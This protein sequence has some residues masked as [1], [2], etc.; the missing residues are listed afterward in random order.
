MDP[1]TIAAILSS[2]KVKAAIQG[3]EKD[4]VGAGKQALIGRLQPTA[5]ERAAK[6]AIKLFSEQWNEELEATSFLGAAI[7]PLRTQ[8]N[9][10]V[11]T[12]AAEIALWM[13]PETKG[14]DL[15]LVAN[16]W[17]ELKL[18]PLPE[19]FKWTR[20]AENYS[21]AI[22]KYIKNDSELRNAYAIALHERQTEALERLAPPDPGFDLTAY[23]QFLI[24]KKCNALQLA[25]L[26]SSSYQFDR[27]LT[28]WSVFVPQ[29][30]RES[31][32]ISEVPPELERRLREQ[33]QLT[34]SEDEDDRKQL[35][36]LRKRYTQT[37]VE[38]DQK[39]LADLRRRFQSS[40]VRPVLEIL[41]SNR[42]VVVVG[43][44][45]SGKTSL[46]KYL[47][48]RWAKE[49]LGLLPV[50]VD[51]KEY[52]KDRRGIL[53]YCQSAHEVFRLNAAEL[54][55]RL[56]AGRAAFYLDGLDEIF[57]PSTRLS[58]IEEIVVL[59]ASY[60]LTPIV[61]TS[62]KVGYEPER[63]RSA[64]FLHATLEE[65]DLSQM[66]DFLRQW[67]RIAEDDDKERVLMLQRLERALQESPAIRELA[68]NPLLL[69]MM[70][71]LNRNQELP[72]SR[73]ALYRE[74]SRVLLDDWDAKKALPVSEFDR[75]DK[76][77]L[78]RELADEMQQAEGGL[79]GNLIEQSKLKEKV[80]LFLERLPVHD[81]RRK[82]RALV[83][84]LQERN[85][86]LAYAGADCFSFVHRTFLEYYCA[87]WFVDRFQKK[88]DLTLEQLKMDV[89]G[90]HWMDEKW[91]EVL[92][93]I[94]GMVEEKKAEQLI[95][96][97]MAQD[98]G[99]EKQANLMIAAG[100][101]NEVR[102][103]GAIKKTAQ[104]LWQRFASEAIRFDSPYPYQFRKE[105]GE[106]RP[107]RQSAVRWMASAWKTENARA[108]L[109]VA[110]TEDHDWI[111]RQ[112][113]V[114][115][116]ARGWKDD[117]GTLPLVQG[118]A[119]YDSHD[120]VRQ[121]AVD[122]LTRG[123]KDDPGTL[124]LVQNLLGYEG[125]VRPR[126]GASQLAVVELTRGWMNDVG[127]SSLAKERVR[128]GRE[129]ER[130]SAVQEL[131][132]DWKDDPGTLPLLQNLA[133]IDEDFSLRQL[134]VEELT[135][136]WKDD[137]GT[138]PLLQSCARADEDYRVQQLSLRELA[139][140]WKDD[141]ETLRLL[142]DRAQN[143]ENNAVR[144]AALQELA[145]GWKDDSEVA[146]FLRNL[147]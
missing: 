32:P 2:A 27:K 130:R 47:A 28:L 137:L 10:L 37:E 73:V 52:V 38:E 82:A 110:A 50:L 125:F 91:H 58:V 136:S 13:D 131:A 134:A 105:L 80:Q 114:Q 67:H 60:A 99:Y 70:A 124:P 51:L 128:Y 106:V 72:R 121:A 86:I 142:K 81:S 127:I 35:A 139:R 85:F 100:C 120:E 63:L 71:I 144:Q 108:W 57:D 87:D 97:L 95:L 61:V 98:G 11:E 22:K 6:E 117:P 113:A 143:D 49:D 45:G 59:S 89:F 25:V 18:D 41:D 21:R 92:R 101:L 16:T 48:L 54:K 129:R 126:L 78:L 39:K 20:V 109:R 44:P 135:R 132:R 17:V 119:L 116:L 66:F 145:E 1:I 31:A 30:A 69:T 146:D 15:S 43:D 4:A 24:E 55:M 138:L 29:S 118:V 65:F 84:H 79:A 5:R 74:A 36:D 115:E 103:R 75:E 93:L 3:L 123:W 68:G 88:Q 140:G 62:R 77:A 9:R 14:V 7:D 122:E 42:Q 94:A 12:T 34:Q 111:V 90:R 8:F 96:F 147:Q 76:E 83:K 141:P 133:R 40:R 107:T 26:H 112:A 23:R 53:E 46:L 104:M 102:N 19:D 64:G 56:L 33:G